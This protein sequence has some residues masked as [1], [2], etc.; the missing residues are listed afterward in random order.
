MRDVYEVRTPEN[1]SFEFELA[2]VGMRAVAWGVDVLIMGGALLAGSVVASLLGILLGGFA[3]AIYFVAAFLVQWGYGSVLEWLWA[4]Q[5]VGKRVVGIRVLTAAGTRISFMQS[6]IRNLAR[7]VD[8]LPGL[9][10]VPLYG[11]GV[12]SA[13]L[14]GHGRR[15]GDLA[16]GT[17]VVR[18][19]KSP[20]P[21]AVIAPV[22]RYNSFIQDPA[23]I[24]A[25]ARITPPER[26]VMLGLAVRRESLPLAVRYALFS[27]LA[28]HLE[29]R[30]GVARPDFFSE[31]RFVLNLA[32]VALGIS[33]RGG[34][35]ETGRP[36]AEPTP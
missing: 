11:V 17:V 1:V 33:E 14:D 25:S 10:I 22:D 12:A 27:K 26:D 28:G 4:G 15:L 20:R 19:R 9:P 13:L 16:A 21:A 30:L 35:A 36:S 2:G 3:T 5:T 29:R 32:A 18:Q 23:I 34:V 7:I 6:V 31:E 8:L 24:H